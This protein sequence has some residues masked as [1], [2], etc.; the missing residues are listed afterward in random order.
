MLTTLYNAVSA[1][2]DWFWGVP[3]LVILIGGA[4]T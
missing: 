4:F 3:A 2:T 1:A